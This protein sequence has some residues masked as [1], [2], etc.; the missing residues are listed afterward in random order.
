MHITRTETFS[1][2]MHWYN[3]W[4]SI[5][6]IHMVTLHIYTI[7]YITIYNNTSMES[8]VLAMLHALTAHTNHW[9]PCCTSCPFTGLGYNPIL[10]HSVRLQWQISAVVTLPQS[11]S[12]AFPLSLWS[13]L[14]NWMGPQPNEESASTYYNIMAIGHRTCMNKL[15]HCIASLYMWFVR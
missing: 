5:H 9:L 4:F 6:N 8:Q 10:P 15:P 1:G 13:D 7:L 3:A 12:V 2:L 11:P 14:M